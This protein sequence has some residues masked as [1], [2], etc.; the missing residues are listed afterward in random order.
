MNRNFR[1][2][3]DWRTPL[4]YLIVLALE[5]FVVSSIGFTNMPLICFIV[6]SC[7]LI[8]SL[9][10]DIAN[11]LIDFNVS[12]K[13]EVRMKAKE[14]LCYIVQNFADIKQ[15]SENSN[16]RI[17]KIVSKN[18]KTITILFYIQTYQHG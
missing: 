18:S 10:K 7:W 16:M 17:T 4:G 14:N 3:F 6:G 1:M 2:P 12:K 15:L 9:V 8:N 11:D 5:S 13:N